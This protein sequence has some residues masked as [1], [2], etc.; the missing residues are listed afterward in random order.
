MR[1][2]YELLGVPKDADHKAIKRA[3]RRLARE[4][5]P[6][7]HPGDKTA[8]NRFKDIH[9]AYELLKDQAKRAAFDRG[10]I[11]ADGESLRPKSY[12]RTWADGAPG[13]KYRNPGET[14]RNFG[15]EDIFADLFRSAG[16]EGRNS[17]AVRGADISYRLEVPFL[18]AAMGAVKHLNL[19]GGKRLRVTIP[20]ASEGGQVLRL[21]G[22]GAPGANGGPS[23]DAMIELGV[24]RH[25]VFRRQGPDILMDLSVT[26][27]EGILGGR[28]DV[29]TI[30]GTVSMSIPKGSNTGSKLRIKGKGV[31]TRG[32]ARGD[33]YVTLKVVLP[34]PPDTS[35]EHLIVE[36]AQAHSYDVRGVKE[37]L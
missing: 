37:V 4:T 36:W 25:P 31:P 33:Q 27:Y 34:D 23:G 14:F 13:G 28:I 30:D 5:H 26:V 11:D 18:D 32:G 19:A 7:L 17:G 9:G 8:E 20:A 12:Y 15:G 6:D 24:A 29:P 16:F 22:Q 2:P 21:K 35:L 1:D 10:E 3:Y